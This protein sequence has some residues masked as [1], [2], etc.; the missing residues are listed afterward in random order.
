MV[1]LGEH[2]ICT[3]EEWAVYYF[4]IVFYI[5]HLYSLIDGAVEFNYIPTD[6]LPS[7]SVSYKVVLKFPSTI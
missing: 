3:W 7:G 1:Y 5:Y 2:S 6:I 4:Y